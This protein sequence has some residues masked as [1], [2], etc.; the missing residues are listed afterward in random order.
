MDGDPA[1][2][3]VGEGQRRV[4]NPRDGYRLAGQRSRGGGAERDRQRGAD[5][6]ALLF[7]PPAAGID[8]ADVGARVN[9][10]LAAQDEFEMLDRIGDV[11]V[12]AVDPGLLQRI[13]E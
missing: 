12:G 13:V 1:F 8:L 5:E 6:S 7:L 11:G 2:A 10:L 4:A 9:T 3:A